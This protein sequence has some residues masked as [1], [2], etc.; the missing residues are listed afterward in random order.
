[1]SVFPIITVKDASTKYLEQNGSVN[2]VFPDIPMMEV[3]DHSYP[4]FVLLVAVGKVLALSHILDNGLF[5]FFC[6][7]ISDTN[8][9]NL[10]TL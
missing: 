3:P 6:D 9:G 10:M 7:N 2:M 8:I 5:S 4:Y 1:M